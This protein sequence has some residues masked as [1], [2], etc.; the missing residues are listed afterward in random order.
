MRFL[1]KIYSG[2]D[3]FRPAVIPDRIEDG[4]VPLGWKKYFD[5][6]EKGAEVWVYFHGP[7]RF[8]PG[9]YIFGRIAEKDP[10]TKTVYLRCTRY[11][12]DVPLTNPET[13]A[14]V[15]AE[16]SVRYRQ[17]F[18]FPE[19]LAP[20]PDC[21][22]DSQATTC[23][24]QMCQD[25]ARWQSFPIIQ[26]ESLS[27]P[28]RLLRE[29]VA[30][31]VAGYWVVPSR[32]FLS[33]DEIPARV[34]QTSDV[35][36]RFKLGESAL[37]FPLAAAL[38][39]ALRAAE[40]GLDEYTAIVP[41]PLSPEKSRARELH[42]TRVLARHLSLLTGIPVVEALGLS[43]SVSKRRMISVGYTKVEFE[44]RYRELL[45]VDGNVQR[46]GSILLLDDVAT[47][48]STFKSAFRA[49]RSTAPDLE[50]LPVVAGQMILTSTCSNLP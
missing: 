12:T 45:T 16:V 26:S 35:F 49:L 3:G 47:R 7:H 29:P 28:E 10:E 48:G 15:A 27:P 25:C 21:D 2:Y 34:Q 8:T 37:G 20:R 22:L 13:S 9:V 19:A 33:R 42:R 44:R 36:Y 31:F 50:V 43:A 4:L 40:I 41:I 17:V 18:Y 24:R 38:D 6:A 14:R 30:G 39:R 23:E 5:D 11:S 32:C 1:F 46:A